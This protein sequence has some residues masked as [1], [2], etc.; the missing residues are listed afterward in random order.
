MKVA[1][2]TVYTVQVVEY[3]KNEFVLKKK[4]LF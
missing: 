4:N 1:I 2:Y 3:T